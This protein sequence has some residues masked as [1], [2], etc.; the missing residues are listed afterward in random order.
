MTLVGRSI[1]SGSGGDSRVRVPTVLRG[2]I[3]TWTVALRSMLRRVRPLLS[4]MAGG[5]TRRSPLAR[6]SWCASDSGTP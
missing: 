4:C 2:C 5:T 3:V 1:V 6:E